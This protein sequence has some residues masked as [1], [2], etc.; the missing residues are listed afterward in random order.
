[1]NAQLLC[2]ELDFSPEQRWY[3]KCTERV[4]EVELHRIEY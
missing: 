3:E 1:M 4:V 2:I